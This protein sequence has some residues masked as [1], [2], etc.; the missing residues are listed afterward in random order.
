MPHCLA[1]HCPQNNADLIS[2]FVDSPRSISLAHLPIPFCVRPVSGLMRQLLF[3]AV[4]VPVICLSCFYDILRESGT[5]TENP[6]KW[7]IQ[8]FLIIM[9]HGSICLPSVQRGHFGYSLYC[10]SSES[11]CVKH[12]HGR[13]SSYR[14]AWMDQQF[15]S[16]ISIICAV[17]L[18]CS[19]SASSSL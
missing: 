12:H 13:D 9:I 4:Q 7:R 2:R 18:R 16:H 1:R 5:K 14:L 17:I 11:S 3:S 10:L 8:L 6:G 15:A 19:V